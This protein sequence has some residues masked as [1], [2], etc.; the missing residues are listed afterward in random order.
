[1]PEQRDCRVF[2]SGDG[3]VNVLP[4]EY[5]ILDF[6]CCDCSRSTSVGIMG[7]S[8]PFPLDCNE[9]RR[10]VE[11]QKK[12]LIQILRE[13]GCTMPDERLRKM[14]VDGLLS[15]AGTDEGRA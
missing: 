10:C 3:L 12:S 11:C 5:V 13:S 7:R 9:A 2:K 8:D 6:R 1:M 15:L 4:D 14:S